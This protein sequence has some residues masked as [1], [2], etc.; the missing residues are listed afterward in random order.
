[1]LC[2]ETWY[3][4]RES[5][6]SASVEPF[7][8]GSNTALL[9]RFQ[10]TTSHVASERLVL[11]IAVV[12]KSME[13]LGSSD[14]WKLQECV[15]VCGTAKFIS[16]HF[17]GCCPVRRPQKNPMRGSGSWPHSS[18]TILT[19]T[20]N[21]SFTKST[22]H[23]HRHKT[24][25]TPQTLNTCGSNV[26]LRQPP[27]EP[28]L[29]G[30]RDKTGN[31][32]SSYQSLARTVLPTSLKGRSLRDPVAEWCNRQAYKFIQGRFCF[33]KPILVVCPTHQVYPPTKVSELLRQ[34]TTSQHFVPS[35]LRKHKGTCC[36][37]LSVHMT[38][39]WGLSASRQTEATNS[40]CNLW[41]WRTPFFHIV[42]NASH[43]LPRLQVSRNNAA[44]Q[45][46]RAEG[47]MH[48]PQGATAC[49]LSRSCVRAK[50]TNTTASTFVGSSACWEFIFV[51]VI[52]VFATQLVGSMYGAKC[53]W[54]GPAVHWRMKSEKYSVPM[55]ST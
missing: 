44:K 42:C 28:K 31:A 1:M 30:W 7:Y 2:S 46:Q 12:K 33:E 41:P 17:P 10:T 9:C 45:E 5:P 18:P 39:V 32:G 14:V 55:H 48:T 24:K 54:F 13:Y 8:P 11:I 40:N 29:S 20:K 37:R 26:S 36:M 53:E 34:S 43:L 21:C 6:Q 23:T 47:D 27:F 25:R 51:S 38:S 19:C 15:E 50:W 35:F 3:H 49:S 22:W 4:F 16:F 52:L